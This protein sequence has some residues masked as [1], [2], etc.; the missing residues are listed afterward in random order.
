VTASWE[1]APEVPE[2]AR[3]PA[4]PALSA[5]EPPRRR[6]A[7]GAKFAWRL[8]QIGIWGAAVLI[9]SAVS[10]RLD[11]ALAAALWLV[12]LAGGVASALLVPALRWSRW[13]WDLRP[14]AIDIQHGTFTVRRTLVPLVRVQHVD[15]KRGILEQMLGLSTVVVHTAAGSHTIP[16][17]KSDDADELSD[18]IASLARTDD[19]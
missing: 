9:G 12:P 17:L 16:L 13:R 19:G 1:D 11:G 18:R 7:P 8:Q 14:E 2:T 4:P 10:S 5:G 6:L 15:T 3:A